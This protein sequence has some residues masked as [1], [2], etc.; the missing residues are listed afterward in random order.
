MKPDHAPGSPNRRWISI[1]K[2]LT[3]IGSVLLGCLSLVLAGLIVGG[4]GAVLVTHPARPVEVAG[5]ISSVTFDRGPQSWMITI[6]QGG[7]Y[8]SVPSLAGDGY[9]LDEF[10]P[11][12]Y[13]SRFR[14]G[15]PIA[16]WVDST[17]YPTPAGGSSQ[18]YEVLALSF[19]RFD[20]P[21]FTSDYYRHPDHKT[22]NAWF[23]GRIAI[24]SAVA[25]V[26]VPI[27]AFALQSVWR[28]VIRG[29]TG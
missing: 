16:I 27:L 23:W 25:L 7:T 2:P 22:A 1:R 9:V 26:L 20:L 5:T 13:S 21:E 4:I 3:A 18:D 14:V 29:R 8:Y 19:T 28:R 24:G 17:E 11:P 6:N 12:A 15:N 10:D